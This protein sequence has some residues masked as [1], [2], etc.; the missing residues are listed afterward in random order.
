MVGS[1]TITVAVPPGTFTG[2]VQVVMTDATSSY[3]APAPGGPP[4]SRSESASTS[5][6]RRS[7]AHSPPFAVTITSPAI[8]AGSTVYLVTGSGLQAASGASVQA[9]SATFTITSDPVVEVTA[10][11]DHRLGDGCCVLGHDGWHRLG[12]G[13]RRSDLGRDRASRSSSR[14]WSLSPCWSSVP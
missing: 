2:P 6:G 7:L 12:H 1:A 9:G 4:W 13:H 11:R 10:G 8:T 14:S 5:M 3:L